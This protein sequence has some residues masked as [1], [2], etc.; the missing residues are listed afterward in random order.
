MNNESVDVKVLFVTPPEATGLCL[1]SIL[2]TAVAKEPITAQ[3]Q[4]REAH[5]TNIVVSAEHLARQFGCP[6][7]KHITSKIDQHAKKPLV[8]SISVSFY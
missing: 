8:N 7:L 3:T 2:S 1:T 4:S 6:K 5:K